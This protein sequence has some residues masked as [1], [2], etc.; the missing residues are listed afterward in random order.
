MVLDGNVDPFQN[1]EAIAQ[2]QGIGE[3]TRVSYALF[4]C[5]ARNAVEP[6]SCPVDDLPKCVSDINSILTSQFE[7]KP[8][9]IAK[10]IVGH[11]IDTMI[12]I[13]ERA[14]EIC[15]IAASGDGT[16]LEAILDELVPE[17]SAVAAKFT[18]ANFVFNSVS[19]PSSCDPG[20]CEIFGNPE[21]FVLAQ[22][23]SIVTVL[24]N[25]QDAFSG[26]V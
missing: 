22:Y 8:G 18:K 23:S 5:S 19:G 17:E 2:V 11:A 6:G 9:E 3:N 1:L 10:S 12:G 25:A 24:V 26:K 16:A 13:H 21:Y 15:D 20:D 7:V 14:Q 4:S